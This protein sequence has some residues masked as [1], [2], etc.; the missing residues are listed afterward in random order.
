MALIIIYFI[1]AKISIHLQQAEMCLCQKPRLDTKI[2][3]WT[4]KLESA[5]LGDAHG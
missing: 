1:I 3:P 2:A 4:G 5:V